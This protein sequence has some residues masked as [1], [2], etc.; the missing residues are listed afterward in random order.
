MPP[1]QQPPQTDPEHW[2]SDHGDAMFRYALLH[3]GD[4]TA[5]EDLVQDALLA[6]MKARED[7]AGRSTVRTWLI[8]ILRHKILDYHRGKARDDLKT[9]FRVS[10]EYVAE[11]FGEKGLWAA[12]PARWRRRPDDA[13]SDQEFWEVYI[14]CLRALT[15]R[16][17]WAFSA[18]EI[19]GTSTEEIC[20]MLA[21]SATNVWTL[22]HRART[23]LR[24]CLERNWFKTDT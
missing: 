16:M 20:K 5:A 24:R 18:R 10:A 13:I 19:H 4:E 11:Q 21:V 9:E 8:G 12:T 2:L 17:M 22:L 7:F 23:R 6:A 3:V 15:P 14:R 1:D